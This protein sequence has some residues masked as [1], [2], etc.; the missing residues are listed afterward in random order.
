MHL[1]V[2]GGARQLRDHLTRAPR[3]GDEGL[4]QRRVAGEVN[5]DIVPHS[6]HGQRLLAEGDAVEIVHA[7]GGG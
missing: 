2:N 5:A 3:A 4:A 6:Q 1:Q 7:P